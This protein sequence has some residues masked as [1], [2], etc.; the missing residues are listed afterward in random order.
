MRKIYLLAAFLCVEWTVKAQDSLKTVRLDDI[1]VTGT[2]SET[3]IEKSGKS[4]FKLSYEDIQANQGK[5][6]SD[7][8]N[9]IPGV[10]MEGNFG[11]QGTNIDYRIRGSASRQ[12]LILIDGIPFNDPSG[13]SQTFDLRYLALDQIESIEVLKG[14]LSTLY[15]TGAASGVINITLKKAEKQKMTGSINEDYGSFNTL[16]TGI[17]FSGQ[18][19]GFSYLFNHNYQTSDG[20][21][22]ARDNLNTGNFDDDKFESINFL[23]KFGYD[24]SEQFAIGFTAA[25]DDIEYDYDLGPYLDDDSFAEQQQ[26][27]LVLSPTFKWRTGRV[28]GDFFYL[29]TDR[30]FNSPSFTT[31]GARSIYEPGGENLQADIV[32]NQNLTDQIQLIG[33]VNYQN[34]RYN[35]PDVE[36]TTFNMLDS[37]ITMVYE[38]NHF[39]FHIGGRLNTHSEYGYNSVWNV[40]PSYLVDLGFSKLKLLGS[41]STS[42]I[43]PSL[44]QLFS[45]DFGNE[46]LN[47]EKSQSVEGGFELLSNNTFQFGTVYFH[48]KD[49]N[50]IYFQEFYDKNGDYEGGQYRYFE[51]PSKVDGI[52]WNAVYF[53]NSNISLSGHYTYINS[54]TSD[55]TL[56]RVPKN[57]FGFS[58][59]SIP[60]KNLLVK[61]THLYVGETTEIGD[62]PLDSYN[63]FDGF[64]SY[65]CKSFIFSAG[66]NNIRNEDYEPQLGYNAAQRN[67]HFGIKYNF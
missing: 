4:I 22:A 59:S 10:Q 44:Y 11:P 6:V 36:E 5:T 65:T 53:I 35:T 13:I 55:R 63:L 48:R 61:L 49:E 15:G 32:I 37:Y 14:G 12:S 66:V 7:L 67:Y 41:Y 19:D 52:E 54:L 60:A 21:S 47:P 50:E 34:F 28:R 16:K 1:V 31:A 20:F 40:S 23:G 27:R 33:G 17:N 58:I 25:L 38:K 29:S 57:K 45:P 56:F 9:E 39:N 43:T 64:I 46:E 24:F 18:L 30:L 26:L 42:F 8:L 62:T 3:T 2:K 51:S